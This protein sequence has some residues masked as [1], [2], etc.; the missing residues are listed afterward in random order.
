M[1]SDEELTAEFGAEFRVSIFRLPMDDPLQGIFTAPG[2]EAAARR[3][4]D[5]I[6]AL[7]ED[8]AEVRVLPGIVAAVGTRESGRLSP[9]APDTA[10]SVL[11]LW[12]CRHPS[13]T[14]VCN[15]TRGVRSGRSLLTPYLYVERPWS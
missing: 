14:G 12:H 5:D 1:L 8:Q 9:R 11:L 7:R 15:A 10:D 2:A 13:Q 6:V 4:L 3:L